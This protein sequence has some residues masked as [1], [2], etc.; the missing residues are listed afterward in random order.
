MT[1]ILDLVNESCV[2]FEGPRDTWR[3][4]HDASA[5]PIFLS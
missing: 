2:A 5:L 3:E 4:L 1:V